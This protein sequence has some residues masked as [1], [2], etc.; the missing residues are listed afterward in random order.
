MLPPSRLPRLAIAQIPMHWEMSENVRAMKQAL[1]VA[2]SDGA[3]CCAFSELAVTGFHRRIVEFARPDV[4][5]PAVDEVR[6]AAAALGIAA[7]FGA[8]TY[9]GDGV[10]F[11]SHLFVDSDGAVV[12]TVTKIGLTEAE[13][14]FFTRGIARST[15]SVVGI[16]CSAVICREIEDAAQVLRDLRSSGVQVIFWPGQMRPDPAEPVQEPPKHVLQAQEL[17]RQ[18]AAY[19]VQ[20]NWPNALNRPEESENTGHSACIA[21]TGELLFRLPRQGH[22]VGVFNLGDRAF[23]WHPSGA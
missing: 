11:N 19:V 7:A 20:T 15:T 23:R 3:A 2:H 5:D 21:P 13:A 17:A 18:A 9:G 16:K 6:A 14:T 8:P 10:R 4:S 22:G 1:Q 12:G